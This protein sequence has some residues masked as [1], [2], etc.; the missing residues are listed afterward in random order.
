MESLWFALY[1]FRFKIFSILDE[2][3]VRDTELCYTF[4]LLSLCVEFHS[5]HHVVPFLLTYPECG[6]GAAVEAE[7]HT[8]LIIPPLILCLISHF[9]L[10]LQ[11]GA[12]GPRLEII[13]WHTVH[14]AMCN[15][16]HFIMFWNTDSSRDFLGKTLITPS[17]RLQVTL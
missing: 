11:P 9:T 17:W 12:A 1:N 5:L 14:S 4:H 15:C 2:S 7:W 3:F 13:P 10:N 8:N 6:D 16:C